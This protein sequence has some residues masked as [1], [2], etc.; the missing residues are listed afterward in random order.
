MD[1]V[2]F[3]YKYLKAT[4]R[5]E[6]AKCDGGTGCVLDG[7]ERQDSRKRSVFPFS[8]PSRGKFFVFQFVLCRTLK[9]ICVRTV[10]K[11]NYVLGFFFL[12]Q[13]K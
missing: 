4:A 11:T 6:D 10:I 7:N 12:P 1:V 13:K 9:V 5:G 8:G 3:H 2:G